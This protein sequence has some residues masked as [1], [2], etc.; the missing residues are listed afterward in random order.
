MYISWNDFVRGAD[1]FVRSSTDNGATWTNERQL[2]TAFFRNVQVTGDLVTGDVYVAAMDEM[3]GGLGNRANRIY[4]STDGGN[5]WTN[6]Y[7]G[8]TFPGPGRGALGSF[9]TMYN[10]PAYWRHQGW[11]EPVAQR[12]RSLCL[13]I[14]QHR[15]RRPGNIFYIRSPIAE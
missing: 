8:P 13:C 12:N 2:S 6:T 9:A 14:P 4:R 7:I 11:G 15:Q 1:I 5:T 10:N 3:G